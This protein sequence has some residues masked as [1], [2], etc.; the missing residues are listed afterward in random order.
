MAAERHPEITT[1]LLDLDATEQLD[2]TSVEALDKLVANLQRRGLR[3]GLVHVHEPPST[4]PADRACSIVSDPITSSRTSTPVSGG[5]PDAR[6]A[7]PG[8]DG[9]RTTTD[10]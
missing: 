9:D 6:M 1:V 7:R 5:P 3:V 10:G 4:W 2:I 8:Q